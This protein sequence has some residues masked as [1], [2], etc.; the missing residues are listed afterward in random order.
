M[1][2]VEI[3][4]SYPRYSITFEDHAGK[5]EVCAGISALMYS[6]EG[7]LTNHEDLL[8]LHTAK[9]DSPGWAHIMFELEDP[10]KNVMGAF[11]LVVI[12]LMQ[13]AETYP[14]FCQVVEKEHEKIF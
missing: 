11:E 13:I 8:F 2:R 3:E 12:G 1:T 6:L 5:P 9:M 10:Y 14:D 4:N 7:F